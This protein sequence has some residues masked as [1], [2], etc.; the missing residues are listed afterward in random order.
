[1]LPGIALVGILFYAVATG[2]LTLDAAMVYFQMLALAP[3]LWFVVMHLL[4][5]IDL[6][7]LGYRGIS[8]YRRTQLIILWVCLYILTTSLDIIYQRVQMMIDPGL[9]S[10]LQHPIL[11]SDGGIENLFIAILLTIV[12]PLMEELVFRG[13][14][15]QRIIKKI[16]VNGGIWISSLLFGI[17]HFESVISAI[18]YGIVLCILY[19]QTKN[20]L[21][22]LS[23]HVMNNVLAL[24]LHD[25]GLIGSWGDQQGIW[26][27]VLLMILS[28]IAVVYAI[29]KQ[30]PK[31]TILPYEFNAQKKSG[32]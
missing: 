19:L 3:I 22:P 28:S 25:L 32:L 12:A 21:V 2:G 23:F 9:E 17:L 14:L 4:G 29:K 11:Q 6:T 31:L 15:L 16:G 24:A 30:W 13:L 20:L 7:F 27:A 5:K 10:P 18:V 8:P 1:M 26:L